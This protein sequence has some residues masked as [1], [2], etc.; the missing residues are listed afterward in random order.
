M[1]ETTTRQPAAPGWGIGRVLLV[2]L[3]LLGLGLVIAL[4]FLTGTGLGTSNLPPIEEL[5]IERI[6]LPEPGLIK[7]S[8]VNGG[9]DPVTVAQVQVDDAYWQFEMEPEQ[10]VPRLGRATIQIPYPWVEAEAHAILLLTSTGATF[11]GEVPVAFQ[12]PGFDWETLLRYALLG[13][14]VGVVPVALGLAWH[15]FLRNVGRTGLNVVLSLTVGLLVFLFIDTLMEALE[16]AAT[17]CQIPH[18]S[19]P[20]VAAKVRHPFSAK[21]RQRKQPGFHPDCATSVVTQTA[22][23][24]AEEGS[25]VPASN[26][27]LSFPFQGSVVVVVLSPPFQNGNRR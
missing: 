3:P 2:L 14:Y 22:S 27:R 24:S 25:E 20:V 19:A 10:T 23:G 21:V 8:I 12:T 26:C 17:L 11:E 4:I 5:T 15:P 13:F 16:I 7:L 18:V 6:T 9:P 1:S